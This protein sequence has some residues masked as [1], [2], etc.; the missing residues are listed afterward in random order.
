M[1]RLIQGPVRT[2]QDPDHDALI[3]Q[4]LDESKID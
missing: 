3:H 4:K 1:N 2:R